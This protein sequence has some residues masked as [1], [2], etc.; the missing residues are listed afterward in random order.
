MAL[1]LAA[2]VALPAGEDCSAVVALVLFPLA[3]F[4][5][6]L[7][8]TGVSAEGEAGGSNGTSRSGEGLAAPGAGE[9]QMAIRDS[10]SFSEAG[11]GAVVVLLSLPGGKAPDTGKEH[12]AGVA[13][14]PRP[15]ARLSS[16]GV[17]G[18]DVPGAGDEA[19]VLRAVVGSVLVEVVALFSGG[20][21]SAE[22]SLH[23]DPV[24]KSV[25]SVGAEEHDVPVAPLVSAR[26]VVPGSVGNIGAGMTAEAFAVG[27]VNAEWLP[28]SSAGP[29]LC[30]CKMDALS[31]TE[32][33]IAESD[34][35][36]L[37]VELLTAVSAGEFRHIGSSW[38]RP[39]TSTNFRTIIHRESVC[40]NGLRARMQI[41]VLGFSPAECQ[42]SHLTASGVEGEVI[43]RPSAGFAPMPF[44]LSSFRLALSSNP[45]QPGGFV[46][47]LHLTPGASGKRARREERREAPCDVRSAPPIAPCNTLAIESALLVSR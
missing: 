5:A 18:A 20:E 25:F 3:G 1:L 14:V 32:A 40:V 17:I 42:P 46:P 27:S 15:L 44:Q 2:C 43:G 31:A 38:L 19:Q 26:S 33:S 30:L 13:L 35:S 4:S 11:P 34:G 37:E 6:V 16:A 7:G 24:L 29:F 47:V 45:P 23:N 9:L 10:L 12:S 36:G 41:S 21:G 39:K 28:A 22:G 8:I